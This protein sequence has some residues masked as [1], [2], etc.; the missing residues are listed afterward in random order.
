[1]SEPLRVL[2]LEHVASDAEL[3][4]AELERAGYDVA[5]D[6]VGTRNDFEDRVRANAYDVVLA[7]YRLP[8]WT[9]MDALAVLRGH[10]KEVPLILV[11]GTLGDEMAVECLKRGVADY[12][13]K[14]NLARLPLVVRR[15]LDERR[16]RVESARAT[17]TIRWLTL[18][19]DQ[20]PASV[21]ITDTA[22][23]IEYVNQRFVEM[24]G[25]AEG[26]AL[27]QS[28]RLLK[29]GHTPPEVYQDMWQTL[30]SGQVWQG[31]LRN[32]TKNDVL[33]WHSVTISPLRDPQ[34]TVTHFLATQEDVSARKQAARR[35]QEREERFRQIADNIREVFFVMDA[36]CR[37]TLYASPAYEEIWGRTCQSLYDNPRSFLEA[38]PQ[39]DRERLVALIARI[40]QG[41]QPGDI[42]Y[43]VLRPDG[44]VRW[45]LSNAA[46]VRNDQ[47]N[48]YR[49][50]GTAMDI[51]ERKRIEEALAESEALY[52][53]VIE[54]SFDGIGITEDG[55]LREANRGFADMFGYTID[56]VVGLTILDF[57]ADESCEEVRRRVSQETEGTYELVGKRK[58]G[59]RIQLEAT[60][61]T[62]SIA[63]RPARLTALRDL[64]EKRQLEKQYR[65]AQKMEAVGRLAGG[66]AH[67]FNNLLTVISSCAELVL[68]DTEEGDSRRE[69]LQEIRKASQAAAGLTRQLLAFSRQQ[70]IEPRLVTIEEVVATAEKMLQRLIGEDVELAAILNSE[71][72]TVRIDPGQL[73]QVIMNL[74]VNARDAMPDGGKLTLETS[75]VDLD[76]AYTRSHWPATS[77]RFALLSVSD[78]GTGMSEETRARIFEPFFTTKE[79]GKGTGLGL[80]TVYGIVKQSGGFIW[81]YSEPGQGTT[82]KIYLPRVDAAPAASPRV[83]A[84]TSLLGTETI[85]LTEDAPAL[86]AAAHQ[87]LERYGYTVL[88]APSSSAALDLARSRTEPIHLLLTDVV[89][90]G[91]SGRELA[92][93]FTARRPDVKVL[94]MSGYTDDAVVRHGVLR[95]GVAYLQK[96]FT[97]DGLARKIR[98]VLDAAPSLAAR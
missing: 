75:S 66:V 95:P 11:T 7:D 56:E 17:D 79:V 37:E 59:T 78:T 1:M 92:E 96:P 63:G 62:H 91:M 80:A 12:V 68:M 88:D 44:E 85:L 25:Y 33:T 67:D 13:V 34:G 73:E 90:P 15:I 42:E 74:A 50:T 87:I 53:K 24:T 23:R 77:G 22:G 9:G 71:P 49:I 18:A 65:Q 97:P 72:A 81:V 86:R 2:M 46:P 93:Q 52:R 39:G 98:E 10:R 41:E 43:R 29:S 94:Y 38:V 40:Q 89:M 82:F 3:C 26:E 70:V 60:A 27:G 47:G 6:V 55:V 58:D 35:L 64:T 84:T 16:A 69:N 14:Q 20:S 45:V 19:V 32:R 36:G 31:E 76:K 28:P 51:T 4:V 30:H 57:V 21:I 8:D 54:T 83:A 61:R 48:V 5:A